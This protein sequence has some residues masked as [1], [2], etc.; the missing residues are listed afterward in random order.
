MSAL[1]LFDALVKAA[2]SP[3]SSAALGST[4]SPDVIRL[5]DFARQLISSSLDDLERV[6]GYDRQTNCFS[7]DDPQRRLELL[8]AVWQLFHD[9]ANDAER[10]LD[11]VKPYLSSTDADRELVTR[12][13]DAVGRTQ[14]RLSVSPEATARA[15]SD[16]K[17]GRTVSLEALR[18]EL[19]ARLRA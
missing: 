6:H 8:G 17:A 12:L 13:S 10:V 14:A 18:D 7:V 1:P 11:R 4:Q 16:A 3:G 19:R 5:A 15:L 9:W 2:P